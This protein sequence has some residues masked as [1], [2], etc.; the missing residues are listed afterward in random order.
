MF[1]EIAASVVRSRAGVQPLGAPWQRKRS[2][3]PI[4]SETSR[5]PR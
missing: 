1:A 2:L 3:A 5:T 4:I